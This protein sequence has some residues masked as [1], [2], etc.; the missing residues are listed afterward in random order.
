MSFKIAKNQVKEQALGQ[1]TGIRQMN[2]AQI[3]CFKNIGVV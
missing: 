2:Y 3:K 1:L